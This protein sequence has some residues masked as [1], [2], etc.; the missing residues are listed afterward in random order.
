MTIDRV[1]CLGDLKVNLRMTLV[2]IVVINQCR[3]EVVSEAHEMV[4]TCPPIL[5]RLQ[6]FESMLTPDLV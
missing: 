1:V 5:E 6:W 4:Y 2:D 3:R